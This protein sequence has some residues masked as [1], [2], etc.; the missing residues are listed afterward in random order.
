MVVQTVATD[1]KKLLLN[2]EIEFSAP[3]DLRVIGCD[4][5]DKTTTFFNRLINPNGRYFSVDFPM[6]I[7]PRKLQV[8]FINELN[9][10][11]NLFRLVSV[12]ADYLQNKGIDVT[13]FD[14]ENIEWLKKFCRDA[15]FLPDGIYWSPSRT[16]WINYMP[17]IVDEN[18]ITLD[19]PARVDHGTGEM[20]ICSSKFR[21]YSIPIRMVISG[22]EYCHWRFDN[23]D[24]TF[25]DLQSL[26]WYLGQG[27]PK[28]EGIYA[29]TN[30]LNES[31]QNEMRMK[32]ILNYIQNYR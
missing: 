6:P 31:H 8:S 32:Q 23:T 22:H 10:D 3:F 9:N 24:E 17:Q 2:Y 5:N 20:Q 29:F 14:H 15:S 18:G 16:I 30:I 7:T 1:N 11:D 12:E 13:P 25:C 26:E 19:T 21:G 27:F 28:T 4:A